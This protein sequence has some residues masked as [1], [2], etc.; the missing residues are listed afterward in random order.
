MSGKILLVDDEKEII[1]LI[2]IYLKN[3]GYE[4][5]KFERG[6]EALDYVENNHVD[7]AILDVM[8]P[9]VDGFTICRKIREKFFFP[10]I[11]LTAKVED[12]DKVNGIMLGADDYITKP[13][14]MLELIARVRANIR[15]AQNYNVALE[16]NENK[17]EEEKYLINGLEINA[18]KHT[19]T[20]YDE[21]LDLT[22]IEFNI[23]LYLARHEGMAVSSEE[24]FEAVWKEKY[25]DSNNTV[26]VHIARIREK[27]HENSRK[28]IYIKTVWGV[29][30]KL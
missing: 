9:D 7:L 1:D 6:Q 22:P 30:Y 14:K 18:S 11:M 25:F 2:E 27:M 4:V 29:G 5:A 16:Q 3:E 28:P 15:R 20:L 19:V 10:I 8:L 13:F 17:N 23:V 26:F 24:L 12:T 21:V